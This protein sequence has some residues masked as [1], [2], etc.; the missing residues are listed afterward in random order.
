MESHGIDSIRLAILARHSPEKDMHWDSRVVAEYSKWCSRFYHI[1]VNIDSDFGVKE[2][3]E[4]SCRELIDTM[5]KTINE[6][7]VIRLSMIIVRNIPASR[8]LTRWRI[9]L[10]MLQS[11]ALSMSPF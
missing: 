8:Y 9:W 5:D 3:K 1:A 6:V 4:Q 7:R 10:S 2:A 11:R